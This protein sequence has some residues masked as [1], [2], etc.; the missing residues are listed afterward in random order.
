[1]P[2]LIVRAEV[3]DPPDGG[4]TVL[5]EKEL[6]TPEG[7]PVIDKVTPELKPFNDF[8]VTVE[9]PE[10]PCAIVSVLGDVESEKSGLV[11]VRVIVTV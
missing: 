2:T 10:A 9:V 4:F 8:T 7:R 3:A 11:T 5:T 6:V 1:M